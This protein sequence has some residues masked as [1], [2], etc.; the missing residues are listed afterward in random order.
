[1]GAVPRFWPRRFRSSLPPAPVVSE[2][3]AHIGP[4]DVEVAALRGDAPE[5]R[6]GD[7]LALYPQV[8]FIG[9]QLRDDEREPPALPSLEYLEGVHRVDGRGF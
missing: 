1:M 8:P 2:P 5:Y 4:V 3:L 9:L 7:E 6:V